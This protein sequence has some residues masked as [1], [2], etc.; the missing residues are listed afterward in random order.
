MDC[1]VLLQVAISPT[2]T[3][4]VSGSSKSTHLEVGS[5]VHYNI[6]LGNSNPW[7]FWNFFNI[8]SFQILTLF[9]GPVSSNHPESNYPCVSPTPDQHDDK[10]IR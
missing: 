8:F 3:L 9:E 2:C 1:F 10:A 5:R 4:V 6:S 7:L